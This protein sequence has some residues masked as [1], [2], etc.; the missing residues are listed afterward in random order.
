MHRLKLIIYLQVYINFG[1]LILFYC[2][3]FFILIF[4]SLTK[5]NFYPNKESKKKKF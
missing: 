3:D 1:H 4:S 2:I 5:F